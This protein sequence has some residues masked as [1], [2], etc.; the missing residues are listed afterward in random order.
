MVPSPLD[1]LTGLD[2]LLLNS[3]QAAAAA[4]VQRSVVPVWARRHESFPAVVDQVGGKKFYSAVDFVTWCAGRSLTKP[5]GQ[6][7]ADAA[8]MGVANLYARQPVE[9]TIAS[10]LTFVLVYRYVEFVE[11]ERAVALLRRCAQASPYLAR[12]VQPFLLKVTPDDVRVLGRAGALVAHSTEGAGAAL[13]LLARSLQQ[14]AGRVLSPGVTGFLADLVAELGRGVHLHVLEGTG[15]FEAVE[16]LGSLGEVLSEGL[17]TS[18]AGERTGHSEFLRLLH[19]VTGSDGAL[20]Y[21]MQSSVESDNRVLLTCLALAKSAAT[22]EDYWMTLGRLVDEA[23]VGIPVV[24]LGRAEFLA[25]AV[26]RD[27]S[28]SRQA[29]DAH[30]D[31]LRLGHLLAVVD[32]GPRGLHGESNVPLAVAVFENH[33]FTERGRPHVAVF[34]CE[35]ELSR[36]SAHRKSVLHDVSTL[37]YEDWESPVHSAGGEHK[38]VAGQSPVG[39]KWLGRALGHGALAAGSCGAEQYYCR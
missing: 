30:H 23:P 26:S 3:T 15:A 21:S 2:D 11:Q 12:V 10:F 25:G 24:A 1:V 13:G 22:Y 31:L 19:A 17:A 16:M 7:A 6:I 32:L 38:L 37:T 28:I 36:Q 39:I 14:G 5:V 20:N 33:R 34:S 18:S 9:T 8:V 27:A 4:G 29:K 35:N